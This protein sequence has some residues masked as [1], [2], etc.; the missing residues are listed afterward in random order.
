MKGDKATER[1]EQ[2]QSLWQGPLIMRDGGDEFAFDLRA[3]SLPAAGWRG[4]HFYPARKLAP[5]A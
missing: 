3:S 4:L 2:E 1:M 5:N